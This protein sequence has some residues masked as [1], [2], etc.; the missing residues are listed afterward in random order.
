MAESEL[1]QT[2]WAPAT[3]I[4]QRRKVQNSADVLFQ[5]TGNKMSDGVVVTALMLHFV[6]QQCSDVKDFLKVLQGFISTEHGVT[7]VFVFPVHFSNLQLYCIQ[8]LFSS[9]Q[10]LFNVLILRLLPEDKAA[11]I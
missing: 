9:V 2:P 3:G 5:W 7:P 8:F 10:F 11:I 1:S 4:K 6:I